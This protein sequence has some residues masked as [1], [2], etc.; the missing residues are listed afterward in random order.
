MY[1]GVDPDERVLRNPKLNVAQLGTAEA[2][3]WPDQS[4]DLVFHRMVA[5]HLS[6]PIAAMRETARVLRPGGTLLFE[7][8]SRWYYPMVA[9]TITPH[10]FHELWVRRLGSGRVS[11]DVFPTLYRCNSRRQITRA[12][13]AAGFEFTIRYIS[14]PPGYLRFHPAAFLVGVL[15]ERTIE[16]LFPPLR[17][18][19]IVEARLP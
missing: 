11:A 12:M 15:Y 2:L 10:W 19:I 3:P 9:A 14:V 17:G 1:A 5:E 4:F 18:K 16:R 8:P 7:T 13:N 6:N